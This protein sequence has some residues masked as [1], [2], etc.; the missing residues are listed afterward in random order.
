MSSNIWALRQRKAEIMNQCQSILDRVKADGRE[1]TR[2]EDREFNSLMA[3]AHRAQAEI[4]EAEVAMNAERNGGGIDVTDGG[5]M[6]RSVSVGSASRPR[7]GKTKYAELFGLGSGLSRGGFANSNEFF[8]AVHTGLADTRLTGIRAAAPGQSETS[9]S[10]GGF[11]VPDQFSQQVLDVSLE[12]E[13]VRPRATVWPM[14][15][16]TR[17]I[18]GVDGYVHTGGTL[19]GGVTQA[20]VNEGDTLPLQE[21]KVWLLELVA[22]KMGLT[23]QASNELLA[24][25]NF[26]ELVGAKLIQACSW[27]LDNAFLWGTGVGMPRGVFNDPALITVAKDASQIAATITYSNIQNMFARLHPSCRNSAVWVFTS[28]AIPQLLQLALLFKNEAGTDYVGGSSAPILTRG[29]N[30]EFELLTRPVLFSEKL[31]AL[32]TVGDALLADFSQYGIGLRRELFLEKSF[33]V[34]FTNDT[35]WYRLTARLDAMGT[36]KAPITPEHGNTLSP[37]V[38]LATRS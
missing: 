29:P 33:H 6:G 15:S 1:L 4:A 20:F 27:L 31:Q 21:I 32:G 35:C 7:S 14:T 30:G 17:K 28:D 13:I 19:L 11:V 3:K 24:D 5:H 22:K 26:D 23:I 18:P 2:N 16:K 34:G 10:T 37:F 38:T 8:A 36:W 12:S 25:G 9:P